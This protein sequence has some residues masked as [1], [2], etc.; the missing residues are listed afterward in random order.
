MRV[1]LVE[2][3]ATFASQVEK[4][5]ADMPDCELV[6][7][8][9]R[10]AAVAVLEAE[11]FELILLDRRIPTINDQL[12][13]HIDH[14][15]A[16]FTFIRDRLPG[17]PVWFLTGTED[18]DFAADL[19]GEARQLDLNGTRHD[20]ALYRVWWKRKISD[21]VK[22]LKAFGVQRGI[23]DNIALNLH[24]DNGAF[25]LSSDEQRVVRLFARRHDGA[26]VTVV[27]LNGGYS[28]S[29]V[30]RLTVHHADGRPLLSAAA[31]VASFGATRDEHARYND[32]INKL[33]AGGFPQIIE[34]MPAGAGA[35]GGIFYGMVGGGVENIFARI[36]GNPDGAAAI[37]PLVRAIQAPWH[38]AGKAKAV[39][40]GQ[41]R[42]KLIGDVALD[43]AKAELQDIDISAVEAKKIQVTESCQHNDMHGANVVF[44]G[45]GRPMLIDFGDAG[46]SFAALDPIT[47]EL[48]MIFH[49]QR[50]KLP[51]TWPSEARMAEWP[52]LD[53]Y[54][55]DC[56]YAGFIRACRQWALEVS[57][58]EEECLAL[59]YAYAVRQLKYPDT[60]KGHARALIK[61]SIGR[62]TA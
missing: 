20:E 38:D 31:K 9:S 32:H 25:E 10:D 55:A 54:V 44:G 3:N 1:L 57:A 26:S 11:A 18:T 42:R 27:S 47:L 60:P 24:Q 39:T 29:R 41:V 40:V 17:T 37:P 5:L 52:D 21:A 51:G 8:K 22:A 15:Q 45:D 53:A 61:A 19:L 7:A 46:G 16:V 2:D 35:V 13:D 56:P 30:L 48:S 34:V 59:A 43:K 6:W 58:S 14:G 33:V 49:S 12:D 23:L 4:A 50:A 36:A 28:D 62:L